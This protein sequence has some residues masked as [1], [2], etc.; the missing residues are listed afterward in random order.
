MVGGKGQTLCKPLHTSSNPCNVL[1]VPHPAKRAIR[2][3]LRYW[4]S[5]WLSVCLTDWLSVSV[6]RSIKTLK[7]IKIS[8]PWHLTGMTGNWQKQKRDIQKIEEG[9]KHFTRDYS[10]SNTGMFLLSVLPD[11][12][13]YLFRGCKPCQR[14]EKKFNR[15]IS[16]RINKKKTL[17]RLVEQLIQSKNCERVDQESRKNSAK[18][19]SV[20]KAGHLLVRRRAA[21]RHNGPL[22]MATNRSLEAPAAPEATTLSGAQSAR[23]PRAC[24]YCSLDA[25]SN[26]EWSVHWPFR[27]GMLC[28]DHSTLE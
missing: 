12:R 13:L 18:N 3:F 21:V 14:G 22:A 5:V 10:F 6:S 15:K 17:R 16:Q 4:P 26:L 1:W 25:C 19:S 28:A 11:Q 24:L 2:K 27:P 23:L 7:G 20:E 9:S 8:R